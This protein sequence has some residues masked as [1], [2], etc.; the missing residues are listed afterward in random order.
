[1]ITAIQKAVLQQ[2][3]HSTFDVEAQGVVQEVVQHGVEGGF[4][5]FCYYYDTTN[6]YDNNVALIWGLLKGYAEDYGISVSEFV[7]GFNSMV[8][9]DIS[10]LL[11]ES[12]STQ[13]VKNALS[14]A[15]LEFCA[16]ELSDYD[17][18]E[19]YI[20]TIDY[21]VDSYINGNFSEMKSLIADHDHEIDEFL[22]KLAE[23]S[24]DV[25]GTGLLTNIWC[26]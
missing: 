11:I 25:P 9:Y 10:D 6:F 5:G 18:G 23:V 22:E 4:I 1:M 3:G 13:M 21:L 12:D 16:Q 14:W 2:L 24:A 15:T 20:H 19:A 17:K 26:S 7:N 8:N